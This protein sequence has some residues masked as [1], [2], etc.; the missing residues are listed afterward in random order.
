MAMDKEIPIKVSIDAFQELDA[1]KLALMQVKDIGLK[2][3]KRINLSEKI[4]VTSVKLDKRK[5][6]EQ[7]RVVIRYDLALF[8]AKTWQAYRPYEKAKNGQDKL[9]AGKALVKAMP[10]MLKRLEKTLKQ[11]LAVFKEEMASGA[12]DDLGELKKAQKA[13]T[14]DTAKKIGALAEA[15]RL[16]FAK[17]I[18]TVLRPLRVAEMKASGDEKAKATQALDAA[19]KKTIE[20]LEKISGEVE[21]AIGKRM[22]ML[23]AAPANM[24]RSGKKDI[25]D[26]AKDEYRTS[27]AALAKA[28]KPV[29]KHIASAKKNNLAVLRK[30]QGKDFSKS[31][32]DLSA[33][34]LLK[35]SKSAAT[36]S[37]EIAKI[38]G[39]LKKLEQAVKRR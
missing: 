15:L 21:G 38:S 29:E 6:E 35:I 2:R 23:L 3:P 11:K 26:A 39:R 22:D 17:E 16:S 14:A 1:K 8:A 24:G 12:R 37:G 5:L 25:S 33:A 28:L 10:E 34:A 19:I 20:H 27:A 31:T 36:L 7:F 4:I 13:L 30:L 32:L 18:T 9:K